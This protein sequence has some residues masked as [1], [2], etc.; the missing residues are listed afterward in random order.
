MSEQRMFL[1]YDNG[2]VVYRLPGVGITIGDV[3]EDE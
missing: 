1:G 3:G 2:R